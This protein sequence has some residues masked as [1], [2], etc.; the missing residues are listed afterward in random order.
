MTEAELHL[1]RFDEQCVVA[2]R[3]EI[4]LENAG[5]VRERIARAV[6]RTASRIVLDLSDVTHLD[7]A[8]VRLLFDLAARFDERRHELAIVA[9]SASMVREVVDVVRLERVAAVVGALDD[10]LRLPA[11]RSQRGPVAPWP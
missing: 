10:A 4:D 7:S 8:G 2:V 9:P 1:Q 6:P 3:G 5:R 11:R